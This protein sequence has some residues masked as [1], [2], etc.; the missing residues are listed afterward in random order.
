[1][2]RK[3]SLVEMKI[4]VHTVYWEQSAGMKSFNRSG[5]RREDNIRMDLESIGC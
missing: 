4:N 2:G 1:M 3:V 5:C